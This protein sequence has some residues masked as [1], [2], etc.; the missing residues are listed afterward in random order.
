MKVEEARKAFELK[1]KQ[2]EEKDEAE[3]RKCK[4]ME[5]ERIQ[6]KWKVVEHKKRKTR[7]T[8]TPKGGKEEMG[9]QRLQAEELSSSPVPTSKRQALSQED[10]PPLNRS[11]ESPSTSLRWDSKYMELQPTPKTKKSGEGKRIATPV[12]TRSRSRAVFR[13][14]VT[15]DIAKNLFRWSDSRSSDEQNAHSETEVS[16]DVGGS[17]PKAV[18]KT[19]VEKPLLSVWENA[20]NEKE[21]DQLRGLKTTSVPDGSGRDERRDPS[22]SGQ[23]LHDVSQ[24]ILEGSISEEGDLVIV[25]GSSSGS[26]HQALSGTEGENDQQPLG[27]DRAQSTPGGAS[28][29]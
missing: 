5:E 8:S 1:N 29:D 7:K 28:I 9:N 18:P 13:T 23:A 24:P 16:T 17:S 11:N 14:P 10:F 21:L 20:I 25:E 19:L 6:K 3:V 27:S 12:V 15:S 4:E 2:Q 26:P 22:E